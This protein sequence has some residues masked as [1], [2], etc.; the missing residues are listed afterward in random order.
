M[1]H[2]IPARPTRYRGVA[3]R[4]RLEATVAEWLDAHQIA[5]QYEPSCYADVGQY[6]PDFRIPAAGGHFAAGGLPR[7]LYVEVKPLRTDWDWAEQ[8][9]VVLARME[10]I[11]ASEPHAALSVWSAHDLTYWQFPLRW[12]H[13]GAIALEAGGWVAC[14]HCGYATVENAHAWEAA[15]YDGP[16]R[17]WT[18]PRCHRVGFVPIS[19][20][21]SEQYLRYTG[22]DGDDGAR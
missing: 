5:W 15:F 9:G 19:P 3:M 14:E 7:P 8:I 21:A 2:A 13:D 6:L 10:R 12:R 11:W 4:S 18:C 20:W 17:P 16:R 1:T 22:R